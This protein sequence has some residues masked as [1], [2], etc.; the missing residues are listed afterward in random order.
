MEE[1]DLEAEG[2]KV[3][4]THLYFNQQ[5]GLP[6]GSRPHHRGC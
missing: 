5:P 6:S 1:V 2:K 4:A 3:F